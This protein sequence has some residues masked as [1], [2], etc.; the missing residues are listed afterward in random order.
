MSVSVFVFIQVFFGMFP[1]TSDRMEGWEEDEEAMMILLC[2][3]DPITTAE[4]PS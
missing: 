1:V 4:V 3:P 2:F